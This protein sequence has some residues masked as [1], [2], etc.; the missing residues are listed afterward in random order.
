[1]SISFALKKSFVNGFSIDASLT[2]DAEMLVLFGPSGAGKSLLLKLIS[3]IMRPDQ[4]R[5]SID[6]ETLFDSGA[7]SIDAPIRSRRIGFLFQDYSLFPHKTVYENVAYGIDHLERSAIKAR[8]GELI[9]LMRLEGL[10]KSYPRHLSGGQKQRAALARTL[11]A[12]PRILLLDEPF[13]ALDY[14]VREKLRADLLKIHRLFPITTILVTHDL[15][16]A[17]M[18]AERIAVINNGRLEHVGSRD[19]VFYRPRTRSVARF[20]GTRNIFSGKVSEA[21]ERI[22][23]SSP[24]LGR[25]SALA[26]STTAF[27]IGQ[28]ASFC[29]RPEEILIVR[30]DKMLDTEENVFEGRITDSVGK[31]STHTLFIKSGEASL[32]VE[33]PNFVQRKLGLALG[34]PVR[35]LLKKES[36]WVIPE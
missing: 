17:F 32:K 30:P 16:E 11:A 28:E 24:G 35:V 1:M 31:G 7:A 4:G 20:I 5:I 15:E 9:S 29:I 18:L 2:L 36:I 6:S 21:G 34:A 27:S 14:Q 3:G 22:V 19:E 8:V 13:S 23:I 33:V 26:H 25:V 12:G 10:E